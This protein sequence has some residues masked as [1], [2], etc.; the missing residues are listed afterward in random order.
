M[1]NYD[2]LIDAYMTSLCEPDDARRHEL[3][4]RVWEEDGTFI[5][6]FGEARGH[7]EINTK[8][9]GVLKQFPGAKVYRTSP[10][11]VVQPNYIRFGFEATHNG[12]EILIQGTDFGV[13]VDGKLNL[14]AGF[15]DTGSKS[16]DSVKQ[17]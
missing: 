1:A 9:Q 17:S 8:V 15:A 12:G 6:P 13:L 3:I 10:I 14:V 16:E 2:E 7:A 11:N 4:K 5:S